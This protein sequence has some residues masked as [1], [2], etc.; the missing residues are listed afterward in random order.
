MLCFIITF[1]NLYKQKALAKNT[2]N[3]T[4]EKEFNLC[5]IHNCHLI[6]IQKK[7]RDSA[8]IIFHS[9]FPNLIGV[10]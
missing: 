9:Q 1:L 5:F 3:K 2:K 7:S 6:I 8:I 4:K 10:P